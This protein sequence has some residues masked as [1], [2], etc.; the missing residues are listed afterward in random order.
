MVVLGC[1]CFCFFIC[2]F[3]VTP[4]HFLS[5][6]SSWTGGHSSSKTHLTGGPLA[7]MA[8]RKRGGR[9][10]SF[11]CCCL[12]GSDH[13]EITYSLRH[14]SNFTLQ[15]MEPTLPM[16]PTEELDAMFTE[17]VVR[18]VSWLHFVYFLCF[19]YFLWSELDR[20]MDGHSWIFVWE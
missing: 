4:F 10:L 19:T 7:M 16:P 15:T 11:L 6:F 2:S 12:K 3:D 13:P 1:N 18:A 5:F 14:G 8:P 9:G 17:L 20:W